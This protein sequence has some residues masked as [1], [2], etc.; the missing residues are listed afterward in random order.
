M[1]S[2]LRHIKP[3]RQQALLPCEVDE[4]L[5]EC[6]DARY[7]GMVKFRA[8]GRRAIWQLDTR[9]AWGWSGR[10]NI[11]SFEGAEFDTP[12]DLERLPL[13]RPPDYVDPG[14]DTDVYLAANVVVRSGQVPAPSWANLVIAYSPYCE[15]HCPTFD[16]W[17]EAEAWLENS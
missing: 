8:K 13:K 7:K 9:L 14:C 2:L 17:Q 3:P 11:Y 16:S 1:L 10:R 12:E 5:P 4:Y 15:A 6:P